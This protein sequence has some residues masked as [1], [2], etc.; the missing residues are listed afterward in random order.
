[1]PFGYLIA[2]TFI[3]NWERFE[4]RRP[5][6][7]RLLQNF[8]G[9]YLARSK[10]V[11][12]VV[13]GVTG[14]AMSITQFPTIA[15]LERLLTSPEW[16]A[17]VTDMAQYAHVDLWGAPGVVSPGSELPGN[18][19]RGYIVARAR[20]S[21]HR[22]IQRPGDLLE[23]TVIAGG[24]RILIR[25]GQIQVVKGDADVDWITVIETPTMQVIHENLPGPESPT[26]SALYR[27]LDVQ[28]LWAVPG[29]ES[30]AP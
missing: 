24:G 22:R 10:D 29:V 6:S 16:S 15:A 20:V 1:M 27:S 18:G 30:T 19:P 12:T 28:D 21:G 17:L 9:H 3:T 25:T 11:Q 2:R 14:F 13:G 23:T 8:D 7:A 4:E 5:I 26:G